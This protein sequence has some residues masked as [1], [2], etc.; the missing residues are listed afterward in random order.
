M[1]YAGPVRASAGIEKLA[2]ATAS[3]DRSKERAALCRRDFVQAVTNQRSEEHRKFVARFYSIEGF[4]GFRN[5]LY[6]I[7]IFG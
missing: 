7:Y 3:K 5:L 4:C 1:L 2:A 6:L